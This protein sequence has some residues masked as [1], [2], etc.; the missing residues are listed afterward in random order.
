[1]KKL[2]ASDI[3]NTI[4]LT[5]AKQDKNNPNLWISSGEKQDYTGEAISA[6]FQWFVH[7][8]TEFKDGKTVANEEYSITYESQPYTL[9]MVRKE[10]NNG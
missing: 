10:L 2:L 5:N 6:V 9:K 4:Y 7:N 1:M 3:S 8:M